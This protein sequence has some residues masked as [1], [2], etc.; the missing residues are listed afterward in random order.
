MS[1][2]DRKIGD[3]EKVMRSNTDSALSMLEAIDPA[4][5]TVRLAAGEISLPEGVWP[6]ARKPKHDR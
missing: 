3:A 1:D 5:I 2:Y 4:D 6:Y